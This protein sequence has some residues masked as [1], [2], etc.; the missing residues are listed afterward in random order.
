MKKSAIIIILVCFI[1]TF[2]NAQV[3]VGINTDENNPLHER[4]LLDINTLS[5]KGVILPKVKSIS[6]LPL[7]TTDTI[8]Y[9]DNF[10]N[11]PTMEGMLMYV[12]DA[13]GYLQYDGDRWIRIGSISPILNPNYSRLGTNQSSG[14]GGL[15]GIYFG[16]GTMDFDRKG[17]NLA[18]LQANLF[19]NL[20]IARPG[21][22]YVQFQEDGIYNISF[23]IRISGGGI[24]DEFLG[25]STIKIMFDADLLKSNGSY[26]KWTTLTTERV[27]P[28]TVIGVQV[29]A[30]MDISRTFT[31]YF[32]AGDQL[33]V[34]WEIDHTGLINVGGYGSS[35]NPRYTYIA[36]EKIL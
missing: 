12:E 3:G 7:Y 8:A 31:H 25:Q 11:D 20:G 21:N 5:N 13:G 24:A 10:E 34:V 29:G 16:D 23:S 18:D 4:A 33:R 22:K 26:S 19:D 36:V 15:A 35:L 9:Y 30:N 2:S 28:K 1:S 17:D 6:D 14:Y 32:K 27:N